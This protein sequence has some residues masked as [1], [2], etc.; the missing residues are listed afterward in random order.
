MPGSA[1]ALEGRPPPNPNE[2]KITAPKAK[3]K[4]NEPQKG[5]RADRM[6]EFLQNVRGKSS[7]NPDE[8][9]AQILEEPAKP[10]EGQEAVS[11][12]ATKPAE[13][14]QGPEANTQTTHLIVDLSEANL[15]RLDRLRDPSIVG[16]E[17]YGASLFDTHL[18]GSSTPAE[19]DPQTVTY[20]ALQEKIDK[21]LVDPAAIGTE[22]V[23]ELGVAAEVTE[24]PESFE[25]IPP[26][27]MNEITTF[28]ERG[29]IT[30]DEAAVIGAEVDAFSKAYHEAYPE[31]DAAK[32][33][34][35]VRDNARK[36][37]YQTKRDK[38][39]FLGSDH[40]IKHIL[41]GNMRFA[42]QMVAGL[43]EQGMTIS[44]KDKVLIRQTIIDHDCG[45]TCGC[46]QARKGFEASKDHPNFSAK[47]VEVNQGYYTDKF[48]EQGYD[49]IQ[50]A[51]LNHDHATEL[52][53]QLDPGEMHYNLVRSVTSTV[54]VLGVTSETKTPIFFTNPDSIR[55]LLKV[56]LA[57]ET[58]KI[59]DTLM[60][61]YKDELREIAAREAN[62]DRQAGYTNAI[63]NFFNEK[64]AELSLGQ[65]TGVVDKVG[66]VRRDDGNLVPQ[67]NMHVSRIHALLGDMFGGELETQASRKAMRALGMD[68]ARMNQFGSTLQ[69]ARRSGV[70]P[71]PE[72]LVYDSNKARFVLND[73][74]AEYALDEFA[75]VRGVVQEA[76]DVSIRTEVNRLLDTLEKGEVNA[77]T[78]GTI[79][80]EFSS[81]I[82]NKSTQEE[83]AKLNRLTSDLADPSEMTQDGKIVTK[84]EQARKELRGFLTQ[85]EK[86]F[87]GIE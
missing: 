62:P 68:E 11:T 1:A 10:V 22:M 23:R 69:E 25:V 17:Q 79:Q 67:V 32:T 40:G 46:A 7:I 50:R 3:D 75:S 34:E 60:D 83:L 4:P 18:K 80:F 71:K 84:A 29:F 48:G 19:Q 72:Q 81:A 41:I 43:E 13:H 20:S 26:T 9:V 12:E 70:T 61:R 76:Y 59:S 64:T 82:A 8:V 42:D 5:S 39:V 31:A 2:R 6:H 86:A 78:I 53:Q 14:T 30:Q 87:L 21:G 15:T 35:L 52:P 27:V 57:M 63:D 45:Y 74:L 77:D 44:A 28:V 58:G 56:K 85:G 49:I 66:V 55:V 37:T 24:V 47:F 51:V 54:D 73:Q 36:L 65:Y 38:Q 33:F 16:K